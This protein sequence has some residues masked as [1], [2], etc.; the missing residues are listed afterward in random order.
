M[1]KFI[2]ASM[3]SVLLVALTSSNFLNKADSQE[4]TASPFVQP[5][6]EGTIPLP[7][8]YISEQ[9]RQEIQR[10]N[11]ANIERLE[12]EGKLPR[13]NP[14]AIVALNWPLQ[15]A[16]NVTDFDI[17]GISNYVDHNPAFP[18]QITDYNCGA[19]SYD[20]A[21]GYNHA[22]IDIFLWPF[23]W[24]KVD[25]NG[26]EIRAAASGTIINKSN[27]NFDR[28]C[29]FNS[30]NWN[31]VYVRHADNSVAWYGHMKNNSLTS[32]NVGDTVAQGEFLGIVGSSGNSTGPHLHF[33]LYNSSNQLQDPYQGT[34]NVMNNFSWWASQKPYNSPF[35]NKLQTHNAPPV[36]PTCPATET[37]NA[38]EYF[39]PGT[40]AA[41]AIFAAYY[42]DQQAGMVTNYSILRPDG[43][44]FQS[45]NHS[46]TQGFAAS[47][48]YWQFAIPL[49][50][51]AGQWKFRTVF[52]SQTSE[53]NF[54]VVRSPFDFDA[55][56]KTD[57]SI[58]RPNLGQWWYQQSAD[59][60]VKVATFGTST[61]KIVPADYDGDAKADIAFFRP[62]T[63]EWFVLR[64]SN[65]T[66]FAAPFGIST[67]IPSPGD[68][69]G[70]G[71]SDFAVYRPS[72]GTWFILKTSGG[73]QTTPFGTTGDVPVV[74]DYDGDGRA[75]IAIFRPTGS[76]GQSEWWMI[77]ST[78]GVFASPF[79][80]A[81]DKPVPG[82]YTGDAKTD[83]AFW[84]PST[85]EWFVL[86]SEDLSFYAAPFGA[87]TDIPVVGDYDADGKFDLAVFRPSSATWFILKSTG[88]TTIQGFGATGDKP[89]P[90][91]Y[92]P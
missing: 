53:K 87:S 24:Y 6:F 22:G 14:E 66:F 52:N 2:F 26:V 58:Y 29:S 65:N 78:E 74:G 19:R 43:T 50:A 73:V 76:S 35:V 71:K 21:N 48:W 82:D 85:G 7:T 34:C 18:N 45:W 80:S 11:K 33:E 56:N 10:Q 3:L 30:N 15:K 91:A 70:D 9:Q 79:G 16:A 67:D 39:R 59:S 92:V 44:T 63:G 42:R 55:D 88:G 84:R 5:D 64:S 46:P 90:S 69:D 57:L 75:D 62:S 36:F 77:R 23:W 40:T 31:A 86:R 60:V 89:V 37:V 27:G 68:F 8:D 54:A 81:T 47:Y 4:N 13:A 28:N 17:Y 20:Q 25:T 38:I 51:Q 83:A 12:R 1:K 72:I 49:N 32:K 61:D 41:N